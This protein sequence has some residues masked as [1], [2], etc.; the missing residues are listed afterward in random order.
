MKPGRSFSKSMR[1]MGVFLLS[2][3]L[4]AVDSANV[5]ASPPPDGSSE[6]TWTISVSQFDSPI[7]VGEYVYVTVTWRP[8]LLQDPG[9]ALARLPPLAGPSLI[10]VTSLI[11]RFIP[12]STYSPKSVSGTTRF[13]YVAD[14]EGNERVAGVAMTSTGS[15]AIGMAQFTVKRCDYRYTLNAVAHLYVDAEEGSYS[16]EY[17][18]KS[19]G[20]LKATDASNPRNVEGKGK[21]IRLGAVMTSFSV[22][23]C[24]LFTWEPGKG[25]GSVDVRA[26]P[27]PDDDS[28]VL[29]FGPPQELH[30]DVDYAFSCDG[31]TRSVTGVY[32]STSNEDPW[33]SAT[34]PS[35]GGQQDI[36]LDMF[37]IPMNRMKGNPGLSFSYT[38]T[39]TLERVEP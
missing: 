38:A 3:L 16:T 12:E 32:G 21:T 28:M 17:T 27:G 39:V 10:K 1:W 6:N 20:V 14:Q 13:A 18:V 29:E 5:K 31:D 25:Q 34:F 11:G 9:Q 4:L 23:K 24:T 33:I 7:C 35:G 26:S 8:N 22:P 30:W 15:D 37:E 36:Q 2:L 19:S